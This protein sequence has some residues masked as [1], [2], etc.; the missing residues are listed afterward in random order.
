MGRYGGW[1]RRIAIDLPALK[2]KPTHGELF[3]MNIQVKDPLW[4]LRNMFDFTFSVKPGEART[5]WLDLRD[6][7][8]PPGKRP[9]SHDCRCGRRF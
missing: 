6:R 5:L 9:V 3:P 1:T 8:L 4:P 2:V 7:I